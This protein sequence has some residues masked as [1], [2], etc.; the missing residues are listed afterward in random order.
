MTR[1]EISAA[2]FPV[3]FW[4][5]FRH[6]S[7]ARKEAL[8][9][10]AIARGGDGQVGF[11]EGCP[12]DYVTDETLETAERFF[13]D[14]ADGVGSEV[15]DLGGLQRWV[16]SH[17]DQIDANPAA[18]AAI[19]I[20]LLDL[21][22]KQAGQTLEA[23]LG[24]PLLQRTLRYSAVLGDSGLLVSGLQALAFR[25]FGLTD[26]KVKLAP[27]QRRNEA[28]LRHLRRI[29]GPRLR[30]RADANNLFDTPDQC[31]DRLGA[32]SA[33]FWAVEEPLKRGDI[34]GMRKVSDALGIP[35][36][37]DESAL[38][39]TDLDQLAADAD[40]WIVNARISKMGGLLR[41]RAFAER[42]SSMGL[43]VVLGAHVGESSILTRAACALANSFEG[44]LVAQEGAF[45][46]RLL[47]QDVCPEPLMFGR[48]GELSLSDWPGRTLPGLGLA[49]DPDRLSML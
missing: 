16:D 6:A 37:L 19:E 46:T 10:V 3:R 9:I 47:R 26:F 27:D 31:I 32:L 48:G 40:R 23:F 5:T 22:S 15:R 30:V 18:F 49:V 29:V 12:R 1:I 36:I 7:A 25:C 4:W 38:R 14:Y 28:R 13:A 2:R 41:T 35:I 34:P 20:A 45:G 17:S 24:L 43:R 42:A 21:L 44:T 33:T 8:N 39:M 11:G